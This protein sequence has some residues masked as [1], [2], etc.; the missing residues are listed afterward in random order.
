MAHS[1]CTGQRMGTGT[2]QERMGFYIMPLAGRIKKG[3]E[4]GNETGDQWANGPSLAMA[5]IVGSRPTFRVGIPSGK[6]GI[7]HSLKSY[8]NLHTVLNISFR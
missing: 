2:G 4:T 6:S 3:A 5:K 1:H 7:R 8:T